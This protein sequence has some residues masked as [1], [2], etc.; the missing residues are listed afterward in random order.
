MTTASQTYTERDVEAFF[1]QTL[2]TYLRFWDSD[3]VLHT[4]YFADPRDDGLPGRVRAHLGDPGRRTRRSTA[5]SSVLDVGCGCG[6]FLLG[7]AAARLPG[8]RAGPVR[9]AD[10]LRPAEAGRRA[11]GLGRRVRARLGDPDAVRRRTPSATWSARTRS[12][13]CRTSRRTPRTRC[14]GCCGRAGCSPS[15]TSC[16]RRRRSASGPAGTC[17]TGSA[18][19]A[20]TRW[21]ATSRRW[22]TPASRS[23][24]G[25]NLVR[26][27]QADLP[28]ARPDRGGAG[29]ESTSDGGGPGLDAVV[30]GVL[31]AHAGGH[32]R[33]RVRL[34][35]GRGPQAGRR[36]GPVTAVRT[37]EVKRTMADVVA[38]R[39]AEMSP[40]R[41][42]AE[43]CAAD[44]TA[45]AVDFDV[46]ITD[47]LT[48]SRRKP[49]YPARNMLKVV[50]L[51]RE[52]RVVV[53]A[54]EPAAGRRPGGGRRGHPPRAGQP[55]PLARRCRSCCRPRP[56]CRCRTGSGRTRRRSSRSSTTG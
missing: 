41:R 5:R 13:W 44:G 24:S 12:S 55:V 4:G 46:T 14:S 48:S 42:F 6:N 53:L 7:L 31:R 9:R 28:G 29:G 10:R 54:R 45:A 20:A 15:R 32:R 26:P 25:C 36:G 56:G 37:D 16:S 35:D 40:G 2:S 11:P 3:G 52:P 23:C 21:S 18:G 43:A 19:T 8:R 33:R 22:S 1:D 47:S 34:G 39:R 51:S 50:D 27:P 49:R 38:Q 17:T 30:R